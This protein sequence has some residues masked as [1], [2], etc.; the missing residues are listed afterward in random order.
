M[1]GTAVVLESCH[2]IGRT[3]ML[4]V[5]TES[6]GLMKRFKATMCCAVSRSWRNK[7]VNISFAGYERGD[8]R[9]FDVSYLILVRSLYGDWSE[10]SAMIFGSVCFHITNGGNCLDGGLYTKEWAI[11]VAHPKYYH[12]DSKFTVFSGIHVLE[13]LRKIV[14][15]E[16]TRSWI[17]GEDVE[18]IPETVSLIPFDCGE[19]DVCIVECNDYKNY[20]KSL[21]SNFNWV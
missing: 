15:N 18:P 21:C 20:V 2:Y 1:T 6:D 8:M 19:C 3:T 12:D 14:S 9:D 16:I 13:G 5:L 17:L 4:R 7:I 11:C 10:R